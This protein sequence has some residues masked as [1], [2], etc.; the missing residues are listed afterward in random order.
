M[1][2][3]RKY[4]LFVSITHDCNFYDNIFLKRFDTTFFDRVSLIFRMFI[5]AD[6]GNKIQR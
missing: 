3:I 2:F 4:C 1:I 5:H 6:N